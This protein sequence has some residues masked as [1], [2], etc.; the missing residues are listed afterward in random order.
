[1]PGNNHLLQEARK[2]AGDE[3]LILSLEQKGYCA[4]LFKDGTTNEKEAR[5]A[6]EFL[7]MINS[8]SVSWVDYTVDD[9]KV[10]SPAIASSLGFGEQL[11]GTLLK[12]EKSGY[13][14]LDKEMGI[15]LPAMIVKGFEVKIGY[16]LIL[17][18]SNLVVTI[19]TSE[20]T[21]FFRLRRYAKIFMRKIKLSL[22]GPDKLTLVIIRIIDE[23]N[24][25]NFDHLREIEDNADIVSQKL[26]RVDTPREEIGHD[27]HMMK[28]ALIVY[29]TGLWE[30]V[31]VLNALRYGD[32]ELLTDDPKMLQRIGGLVAEVNNQIGLAEHMSE[33]LASG[34]EVMQ[35]IY[36]NQL[37]ILNNKLAL[38]VAYLTVLGTAFLVPNTIATALGSSAFQLG[39]EDQG[40]YMAM[41]VGSTLIAT[42]GSYLWVKKMG[43]LPDK[44]H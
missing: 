11:V 38:L 16:I 3:K 5:D 17:M 1:M 18:R 40:W 4:A 7:D 42:L 30:T 20:V 9:L 44:T 27:I 21:R 2:K 43:L 12:S 28:H 34:L 23:N 29:L 32:P 37:Q 15:L 36:N 39:P 24:G 14:D 26:S 10:D 22:S 8:S 35:S 33:V 41:L 6:K 31:D 19:H 25:K 13:E